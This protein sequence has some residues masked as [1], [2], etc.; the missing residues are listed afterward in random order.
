MRRDVGIPP[1]GSA[2]LKA[3]LGGSCQRQLTDEGKIGAVSRHLIRLPFG[4]PPSPR[5]RL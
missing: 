2:V 3:S 4:Q 5:G 1:Y